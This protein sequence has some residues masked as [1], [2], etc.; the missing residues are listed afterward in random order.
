MKQVSKPRIGCLNNFSTFWG[1]GH[2]LG[3]RILG[4]WIVAWNHQSGGDWF[5]RHVCKTGEMFALSRNYLGQ[6]E[7]VSLGYQGPKCQSIKNTE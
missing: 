5:S 1:T 3:P 6:G 4:M 7:A 2:R